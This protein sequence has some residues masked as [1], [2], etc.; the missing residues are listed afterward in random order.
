MNVGHDVPL[1][2]VVER[3]SGLECKLAAM[4]KHGEQRTMQAA[5]VLGTATSST[6][7][8]ATA[9]AAA[10]AVVALSLTL[11]QLQQAERAPQRLILL[12]QQRVLLLQ[13]VAVRG[14]CHLIRRLV[15]TA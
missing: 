15:I 13:L 9:A 12:A 7:T 4:N 1:D 10:A 2:D 6:T 14:N 3:V 11:M 8:A 5:I